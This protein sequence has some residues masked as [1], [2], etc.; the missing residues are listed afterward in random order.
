M[1]KRGESTDSVEKNLEMWGFRYSLVRDRFESEERK[2]RPRE[3]HRHISIVC[4]YLSLAGCGLYPG[5]WDSEWEDGRS[6][7]ACYMN[8]DRENNKGKA[9]APRW[10]MPVMRG[11]VT[12]LP[13]FFLSNYQNATRIL[14]QF[15]GQ[16]IN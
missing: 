3:T 6:Q 7:K 10:L 1:R 15:L 9:A 14:F 5:D 8:S 12:L 13:L 16:H 4:V 2:R 11:T